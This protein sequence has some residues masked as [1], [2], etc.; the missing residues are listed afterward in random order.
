[1][2][3]DAAK[4]KYQES[5]QQVF[6][7]VAK[8]SPV[9]KDPLFLKQPPAC[10]YRDTECIAGIGGFSRCE[11]VLV[12]SSTPVD[13]GVLLSVRLIDV[14]KKKVTARVDEVVVAEKEEQIAAWAEGHA[15]RALKVKCPGEVVLDLDRPDMVAVID[16]KPLVRK[17][18]A[19][20][21]AEK[22]TLP[23]GLHMVRV[24]IGRRSSLEQPLV[25]RRAGA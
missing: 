1:G 24:S 14:T 15:C 3:A 19:T 8:A 7:E 18:P 20:G 2:A 11:N 12:G 21:G 17:P 10:G 22:I 23:A 25:I 16:R 4:S 13:N 6:Y 9:L 5:L